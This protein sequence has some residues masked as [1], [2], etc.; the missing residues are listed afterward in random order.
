MVLGIVAALLPILALACTAEPTA[1][2][3]LPTGAV[4]A[5]P[6]PIPAPVKPADRLPPATVSPLSPPPVPPR[7]PETPPPV[8]IPPT[9]PAAMPGHLATPPP[10]T[11][12][13]PL[14]QIAAGRHAQC[15][16]QVDGQVVCQRNNYTDHAVPLLSL[17]NARFR[18]VSLGLAY[19]CGLRRDG[20]IACWG[21]PAHNKTAPPPG[22]F[23]S[24]DAGKQHACALD[25]DGYAQCWGWGNNGRA[26]PPVDLAFT[27]IGAGGSHSCGLTAAGGALR[28]WG[29]NGR[30]QADNHSGPFQSLSLG[31]WN[32]CALRPEGTAWCQG[33]DAAGQ[34]SPPPGAFAQIAAG[35]EYACGL[36]PEGNLECW[37]GGF[38]AE[39]GEPAGEFMTVSGSWDTFCALSRADYAVCWRYQPG[40]PQPAVDSITRFSAE[41]PATVFQWPVELFPWPEGGLAVVEREGLIIRCRGEVLYCDAGGN[42][43]LLDL[44]EQVELIELESGMLSAAVDPDFDRFPFLYVYYTVGADPRKARLSRFPVADGQVDRAGELALLELPMPKAEHFGGAIRFGPD[45]MLYLGIGDNRSPEEAQS[46]A[47][48][49]G[50]IIRIDARG[51]TS[52]QPYG[53][54]EDNPYRATEGALPEIWAYGLRN[55]W[56]M[57]F[58]AAGRLWVG[59]VGVAGAEEVSIVTASANLGWPIFEGNLCYGE[60]RECAALTDATPPVIDYGRGEGCAIIWGGEYRGTARPQLAGVYFFGDFCSR[61]IWALTP[62]GAGGWQRRLAATVGGPLLAFGTDAAGELY[63]L[64]VNQPIVKLAAVV[65][66]GPAAENP[67]GGQ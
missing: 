60:E 37:G 12:S 3:P 28:C 8:L 22:Q 53:I 50:K 13:T 52:E 67:A 7:E 54:P 16:L 9:E 62:D 36:R 18:Q 64:S 31:V 66:A 35:S 59:D 29:S 63:A 42:P 5:I 24:V 55:P 15:G 4:P 19:A 17:S 58:D 49:R 48:L 45:G 21:N 51:A 40:S 10:A 27:A 39:L 44:T 46:R 30:G 20:T 56:R 43:P 65:P 61:R 57:S 26:T 23:T 32:T 38:G 41:V 2:P 47:S 6:T 14:I 1:I 34:S 25:S 11:S 33:E